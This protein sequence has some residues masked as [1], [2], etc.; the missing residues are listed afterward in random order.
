M[1]GGGDLF[2]DDPF[3]APPQQNFMQDNM[4]SQN[5]FNQPSSGL[6]DF[7]NQGPSSNINANATPGMTPGMPPSDNQFGNS[8]TPGGPSDQEDLFGVNFNQSQNQMNQGA[9]GGTPMGDFN[10][11]FSANQSQPPPS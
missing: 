2:D 9:P 8:F 10:D 11:V 5:S 4:Q 3:G 7:L 1:N 6:N